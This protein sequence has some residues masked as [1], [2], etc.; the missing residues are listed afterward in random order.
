MIYI[1][2]D[3]GGFGLKQTIIKFLEVNNLAV[4]DIGPKVLSPD[5]DYPDYVKP[6]AEKIIN[7]PESKGIVLCKN[8]VGVCMYANKFK[9][10]R[11]GLSWTPE[12]AKTSKSD[13]NT[14]VLAL[15]ALYISEDTA[16]RT[17]ESWLKT[18]F[19]NEERHIRRL[20]K[21]EK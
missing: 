16:L 19:S 10:I 20:R 5:D 7:D 8:G 9:G 13:D 18:Q 1:A 2:S 3:H 15:P 12:H 6:L 21:I 14:N 4:E 11:A 17:V